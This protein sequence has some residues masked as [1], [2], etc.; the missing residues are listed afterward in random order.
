MAVPLLAPHVQFWTCP[1]CDTVDRTEGLVP[2]RFHHCRGAGVHAGLYAPLV[3]AG[4]KAK[5][6]AV[7]REDY[8]GR[9]HVQLHQ[10][11]PVM[12][13]VVTRDDG[14][15]TAVFAPTAHIAAD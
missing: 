12:S 15:D 13:V 8:I 6:E 4:T 10:G 3:P 14:M 9:E 7:E 11:R 1:N 5:V 2:N